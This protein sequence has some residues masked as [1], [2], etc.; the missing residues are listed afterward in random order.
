MQT[1]RV[2][3]T[4]NVFIDYPLASI[5]ER[6]GA[7]LIDRIILFLYVLMIA[8]VLIYSG[9]KF[10]EDDYMWIIIVG[11]ILIGIPFLFAGL[12]FEIFMDGQTPGKRVMKIKVMRL[13]GTPAT[14]GG[15]LLR[16]LFC[17]V[18][19]GLFSGV[20]AVVI[21]ALGGKG[22]R[23]GDI[24]AG[25]TVVKLTKE[26]EVTANEVFITAE[27][28]YVPT[29]EQAVQLNSRD[30]EIIQRALEANRDHGNYEPVEAVTE[31]LKALLGIQSDLPPVQFLTTLV[32]DHSNLTA[33]R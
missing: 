7:Y 12:L 11:F 29:F 27:E 5:G 32:K 17:I 10:G 3:T 9:Y 31:K 15:F 13:D 28:T 22:Q 6:I 18:D 26:K 16:W 2:Q 1:I 19:F 25:T 8:V 33:G 4:Q 20:I 23:L 24:V 21:I 14:V 30:I